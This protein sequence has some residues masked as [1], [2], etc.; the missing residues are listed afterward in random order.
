MDGSQEYYAANLTGPLVLVIGGE[1]RGVSRLTRESCDFLV[2]LPMQG[3]IN[4][5][6]ASVAGSILMYEVLRQRRL[7]K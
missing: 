2:Q 7:K 6:N 1:G 3:H 4:S 5:L